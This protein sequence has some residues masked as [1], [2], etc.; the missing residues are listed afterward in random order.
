MDTSLIRAKYTSDAETGTLLALLQ[1]LRRG[2]QV[3]LVDR[4]P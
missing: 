4:L 1:H 3:L 2:V